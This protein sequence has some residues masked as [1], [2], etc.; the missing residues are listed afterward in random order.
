M[1]SGIFYAC[2]KKDYLKRTNDH[3]KKKDYLKRGVER[4]KKK[5][6]LKRGSTGA[7]TRARTESGKIR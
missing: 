1:P 5:D 3:V 2:R 7:R 4:P 6:Y